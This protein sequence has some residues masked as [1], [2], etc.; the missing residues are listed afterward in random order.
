MDWM[1]VCEIALGI[2]LAEAALAGVRWL[3]KQ[4]AAPVEGSAGT[5]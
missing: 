5:Y 4:G 2:L 1:T 3:V